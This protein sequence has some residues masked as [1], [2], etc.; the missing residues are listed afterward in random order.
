MPLVTT[1]NTFRINLSSTQLTAEDQIIFKFR[2][3]NIVGNNFTASLVPTA[4]A[5]GGTNTRAGS[6]SVQSLSLRTGFP[7][8]S[9]TPQFLD[10][11]SIAASDN[12]IVF[13]EGVTSFH[14]GNY[15]FVP[16]PPTGSVSSSLYSRYGDVDYPFTAKT[17]DIILIYLS[18]GTYI[19]YR[20]IDTSVVNNKLTLTLDEN[21]SAFA[22]ADLTNTS[23][24]RYDHIILLTRIE[25]ETNAYIV[26]SKRPG[27]TSYGFSIPETLSPDMLNNIDIITKEVKQKLLA[28]QQGSTSDT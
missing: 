24:P 9:C 2:A 4:V 21:L 20:V 5:G 17:Y 15:V 26:Y 18:D 19:E 8:V 22:K 28:D 11:S 13:S 10:S 14:G 23:T 7:V 3:S 16:N 6:L 12:K 27:Q 1:T 25:D